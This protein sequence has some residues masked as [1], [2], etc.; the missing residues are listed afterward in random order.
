LGICS[1]ISW[2]LASLIFF[3]ITSTWWSIRVR[4]LQ[5][6]GVYLRGDQYKFGSC[7]SIF[8]LSCF[9]LHVCLDFF[10]FF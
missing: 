5:R 1:L 7:H 3:V 4:H 10:Q 9:M 2:I 6:S 8:L